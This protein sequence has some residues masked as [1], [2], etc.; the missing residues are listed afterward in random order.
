ML[1]WNDSMNLTGLMRRRERSLSEKSRIFVSKSA[2]MMLRPICP[3]LWTWPSICSASITNRSR[4][5]EKVKIKRGTFFENYFSFVKYATDKSF[6]SAGE[7][8]DKDEWGMTPQVSLYVC[9]TDSDME[10]LLQSSRE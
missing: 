1:L 6:A 7:P 9:Y 2:T 4:Y 8:V 5:Y 10:C 3:I